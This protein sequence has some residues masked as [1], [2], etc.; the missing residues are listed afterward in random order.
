M[1]KNKKARCPHCKTVKEFVVRD[2]LKDNEGMAFKFMSPASSIDHFED[3]I[4][5]KMTLTCANP[6]C[7][8]TFSVNT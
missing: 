6:D 8:K 4:P 1:S 2:E 5:K 3:D 7:L